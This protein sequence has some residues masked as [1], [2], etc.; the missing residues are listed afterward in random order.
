MNLMYVVIDSNIR[1]AD[2]YRIVKDLSQLLQH[3]AFRFGYEEVNPH[4][5]TG[6]DGDEKLRSLGLEINNTR[7]ASKWLQAYQEKSPV[8]V[9][10]G[11]RNNLK[12]DQ[13]TMLPFTE[14]AGKDLADN[15]E[16]T[17][18]T[19]CCVAG[20]KQEQHS[21]TI[22]SAH[23]IRACCAVERD[24]GSLDS[25]TRHA[26]SQTNEQQS[27]SAKVICEAGSNIIE[28]GESNVS[29]LETQLGA[30]IVTEIVP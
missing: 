7:V 10:K 13:A 18:V 28:N 14:M 21:S 29:S 2:G 15:D 30:D 9:G 25:G 11:R 27:P 12:I 8:D 3:D 22:S 16:D 6:G 5:V 17:N 23:P 24:H 20:L 26:P 4:P 19:A 1:S